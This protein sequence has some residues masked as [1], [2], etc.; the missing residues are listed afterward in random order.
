MIDRVEALFQRQLHGWPLLAR[1][2]ESL[3]S[4]E[5]RIVRIDWYEVYLRHIPHRVV[6]TTAA[7]DPA[8]VAK[9]PCFLCAQ[10]LPPEEE[11]LAFGEDL[12]IYCNPFPIVQKHLTIADR[13]HTPQRIAERFDR[14]LDLAA[15]LDG[16]F[17]IYNGPECGASAPDH[18]HFQAGLRKDLPIIRDTAQLNSL[19]VTNYGRRLL[20]FHDND[21][22]RLIDTLARATEVLEQVTCKGPEPLINVA[23]LYADGRWTVYLFPRGKHRPEVFHTG[24]LT[25]SPATI[26]LC[27]ILVVS[28]RRDFEKIS[29]D[30]VAAIFDEV[31]LPVDQFEEV[32]KR[33]ERVR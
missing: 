19:A 29:G 7:V 15:A 27:G 14:M 10:N 24:E 16:Y 26:D 33:L 3:T 28:M 5:Q 8:S 2:V 17:V 1:G 32:A 12:V 25:V 11:G 21:Y 6:S 18:L 20:I 4:A 31:S 22:R 13:E 9:R 30:R 23:A